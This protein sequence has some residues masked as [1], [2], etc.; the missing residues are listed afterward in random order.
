MLSKAPLLRGFSFLGEFRNRHLTGRL[1]P[2]RFEVAVDPGELKAKCSETTA[3]DRNVDLLPVD[4]IT[5]PGTRDVV[6]PSDPV[7]LKFDYPTVETVSYNKVSECWVPPFEP[8][9]EYTV[10]DTVD[11]DGAEGSDIFTPVAN[12][13]VHYGRLSME[14]V[15]GR[16]NIDE[17][18]MSFQA[19]C[20]RG[21]LALNGVRRLA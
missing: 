17:L 10:A 8:T 18:P 11:S 16:E 15:S 13:D 2:E 12:F 5:A 14:N 1:Y 19:K 21:W 9:L 7:L 3:F 6:G 4:G 20:W